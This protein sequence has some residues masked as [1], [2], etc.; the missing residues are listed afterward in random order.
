MQAR[1]KDIIAILEQHFPPELAESW[2]NVG[3]QIGS[4]EQKVKRLMTALD[5]DNEVLHHAQAEKIDLIVT[6]HPLFFKPF[7][8]IDLDTPSGRIIGELIRNKISVYSAHTNLDAAENGLNQI[9]AEKL[10]LINIEPL[11]PAVRDELFKIV[12]FVPV[13]HAEMVRE[14]MSR[15]GA[16]YIGNYSDCSF[17]VRGTGSFRPGADAH[18]YI[19]T[20]GILEEVDEYRLETI[21]YRKDINTILKAMFDSHP[22]EE[23]AYDLYRLENEGRSYCPGRKGLLPRA[24]KVSDLAEMIKECLGLD[25]VRFTGLPEKIVRKIAVVSGAGASFTG[26]C[27]KQGCE[28]L[29]TGDLKYHEAQDAK[30]A[31]LS[32]IDAGHQG[33]EQI[34]VPFLDELLSN[35]C[36]QRGFD[37]NIIT[38]RL[39]NCFY[40]V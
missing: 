35:A 34:V 28:V 11:F 8:K 7:K 17:R 33:T 6:H 3:L 20:P 5:I 2:D 10:G 39:T 22:Y 12:V 29:V 18:A 19:G 36:K 25:S 15:A 4:R 24:C 1:V 27:V 23:P 21:A 26:E 9:L 14:A 30:A 38:A 16:G 13:S 37:I 31:G 40:N 32:I